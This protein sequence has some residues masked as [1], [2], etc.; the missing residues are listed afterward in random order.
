MCVVGVGGL[1][2]ERGRER[3]GGNINFCCYRVFLAK[4]S[5]TEASHRKPGQCIYSKNIY[6][7]SNTNKALQWVLHIQ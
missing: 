7:A 5:S 2:R 4:R 3:E 1:V 6:R